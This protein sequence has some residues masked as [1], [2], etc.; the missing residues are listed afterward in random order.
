[1]HFDR[2]ADI[3]ERA[4]PPYPHALWQRLHQLGTL[5]PGV[6]ALDIGA[7][8]GQATGPLLAA[9]AT[10]TAVEPGQALAQRLRTRLPDATILATTAE[11]ADLPDAAYDLAVI[12]TAVHW[13]NLDIVL[14]KLHQALA[15][16]GYLAVWR[17]AFG[18][19]DVR[20]PFRDRVEAIV[21]RRD[22]ASRRPGPGELDTDEWSHRL[23]ASGHFVETHRARFRWTIDL[24]AD[25]IHDLFTTFSDWSDAEVDAA[26]AAVR[27]L[28]GRVTEHYVTPLIVLSRW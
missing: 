25:Q 4:R 3:Y 22:P 10:V 21:A 18:D 28:G 11:D 20:T 26:A 5:H 9:G 8:T 27:D 14:P 23:T 1:M 16:G 12:A 2:N 19:P 6:R 17:N 13:L 24:D 15:A 7:G